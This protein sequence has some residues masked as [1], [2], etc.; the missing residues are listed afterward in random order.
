MNSPVLSQASPTGL[1]EE[2]IT[3]TSVLMLMSGQ[4]LIYNS[5]NFSISGLSEFDSSTDSSDLDF[6]SP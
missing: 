5:L 1:C 6:L 3:G 2:E 4:G